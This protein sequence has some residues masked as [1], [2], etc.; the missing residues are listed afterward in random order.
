M[1]KNDEYRSLY[2]IVKLLFNFSLVSFVD[3]ILFVYM[4]PLLD[5][6]VLFCYL[7]LCRFLSW[8]ATVVLE[9]VKKTLSVSMECKY[10]I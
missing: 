4:S 8:F 7:N 5:K 10:K 9:R 1:D 3:Y 2:F 6:R